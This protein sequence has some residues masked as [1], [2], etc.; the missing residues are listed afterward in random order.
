MDDQK[1][2]KLCLT[3]AGAVSAGAYTAG[4][5]DYLLESLELW[6][7]A[8][9]TNR[10][11]GI[12]HPDYDHSIPMHNVEI[13]VLSGSSAG[14]ICSTLAFLA[15]SD[16][17]F[18]SCNKDNIEGVDNVL[19]KSWVDMGDSPKS[20]TV[21]KLLDPSDLKKYNEIRSLLNS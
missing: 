3:M 8:K 11:R 12:M 13:D 1:T 19:Y 15:L 14:G 10:S 16:K 18:R 20:S 6:E 5:L 9:K 21:D 2:F 7:R 4:V 17:R